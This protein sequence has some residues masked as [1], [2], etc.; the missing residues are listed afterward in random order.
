MVMVYC[1]GCGKEIHEQALLCPQC[2]APQT[3]SNAMQKGSWMAIIATLVA[4]LVLLGSLDIKKGEMDLVFGA[5][6]LGSTAIALG[7]IS[8]HQGR[9]GKNLAIAAITV[10]ALAILTALVNAI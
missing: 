8:L 9:P 2:G 7:G 10:A 6:T 1:R 3:T 5:F 4:T